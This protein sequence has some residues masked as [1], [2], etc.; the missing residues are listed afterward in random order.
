MSFLAFRADGKKLIPVSG[1]SKC[2]GILLF[3]LLSRCDSFYFPRGTFW[4]LNKKKAR[5]KFFF[6][7]F[8][9]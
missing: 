2:T 9:F 7:F 5:K 3:P 1:R 4:S 6:I 8:F